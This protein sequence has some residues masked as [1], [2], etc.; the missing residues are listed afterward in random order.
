MAGG[1]GPRENMNLSK[2]ATDFANAAGNAVQQG[3]KNMIN[4]NNK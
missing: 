2:S 1:S 4:N 3:M